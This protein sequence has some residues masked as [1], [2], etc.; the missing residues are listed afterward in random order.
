MTSKFIIGLVLLAIGLLLFFLGY[1]SSQGLDDQVTEALTGEYTDSTV[2][3]WVL[4][5]ISSAAGVA[6][7]LLGRK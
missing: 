3:Y 1:Q 6:M 5:A 7:L 2:W 4:G